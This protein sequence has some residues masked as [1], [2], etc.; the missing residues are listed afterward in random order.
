MNYKLQQKLAKKYPKI[1]RYIGGDPRKTCMAFGIETGDGWYDIING[2]CEQI[3]KIDPLGN[4]RASQVKEKFGGLRFCVVGATEEI[5]SLIDTAE[6][7]SF[8]TC[9]DC[10]TREG[11]TTEG[12]YLLT[13]CRK[14]RKKQEEK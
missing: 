7:M 1:F 9:E 6:A 2:L 12:G 11:V 3:V 13:L 4:V 8:E 5:Y 10:G 14:C